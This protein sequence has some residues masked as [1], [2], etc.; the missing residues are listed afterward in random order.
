METGTC[1]SRIALVSHLGCA[2]GHRFATSRATFGR[3]KLA[4]HGGEAEPQEAADPQPC[5]NLCLSRQVK[6]VRSRS[7]TNS[8]KERNDREG[9]RKATFGAP[10]FEGPLARMGRESGGGRGG[11]ENGGPIRPYPGEGRKKKWCPVA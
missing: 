10:H 2:L 7:E 9:W 11:K 8:G 5:F 6:G 4:P 1:V 3:A